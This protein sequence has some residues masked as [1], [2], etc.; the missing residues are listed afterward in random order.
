MM[1][2]KKILVLTLILVL[3]TGAGIAVVQPHGDRHSESFTIIHTNDTHCF[4]KEQGSAGFT[5]VAA[6]DQ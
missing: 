5:T 3:I 2:E 4:F 6:L 1:L